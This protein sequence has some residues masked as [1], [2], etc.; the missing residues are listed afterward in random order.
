MAQAHQVFEKAEPWL[1]FFA[2]S[3]IE[4]IFGMGVPWHDRHQPNTSLLW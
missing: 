3:R 1:N 2:L 4:S